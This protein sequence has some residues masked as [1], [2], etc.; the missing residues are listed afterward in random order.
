MYLNEKKKYVYM[1]L[2]K[3][4]KLFGLK[5]WLFYEFCLFVF[6]IMNSN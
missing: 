4:K 6:M 2:F 1:L 5:E 3:R